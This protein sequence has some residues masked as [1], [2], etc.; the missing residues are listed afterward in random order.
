MTHH[1]VADPRNIRGRTCV[2]CGTKFR[3]SPSRYFCS[4]ACKD[5]PGKLVLTCPDCGDSF[6]THPQTKRR[7]CQACSKVR[8]H[9]KK[10]NVDL[11]MNGA[12]AEAFL[13]RAVA[14]ETLM[15]W[16][17]QAKAANAGTARRATA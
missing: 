8:M 5:S 12:Q 10:G 4:T 3:G 11:G 13:A 14:N 7:Y 2:A 15:P 17:K 9:A 16:E 1:G 6:H